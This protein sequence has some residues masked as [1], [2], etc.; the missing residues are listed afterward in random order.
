MLKQHYSLI[1]CKY[2][3]YQD[4]LLTL[5]PIFEAVSGEWM[6][7]SDRFYSWWRVVLPTRDDDMMAQLSQCSGAFGTSPP[8]QALRLT[9]V[10]Y[11]RNRELQDAQ[12]LVCN[13]GGVRIQHILHEL[14]AME[15][16]IPAAPIFMLMCARE[17]GKWT[18]ICCGVHANIQ[19]LQNS[20]TLKAVGCSAR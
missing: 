7:C 10:Y 19:N 11:S 1:D 17:L 15:Q 12:A 16:Y 20:P 13:T 3:C 5:H 8:C 6:R 2:P 4:K 14:E 18:A 9:A